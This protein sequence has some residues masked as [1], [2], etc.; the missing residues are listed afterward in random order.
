M[1]SIIL[2]SSLSLI[3]AP[4]YG[5]K[6][7]SSAVPNTTS[8]TALAPKGVILKLIMRNLETLLSLSSYINMKMKFT[9]T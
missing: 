4:M 6:V 2:S 7:Q 5:I 9:K 8:P 1:T 3:W